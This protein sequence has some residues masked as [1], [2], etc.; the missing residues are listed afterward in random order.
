MADRQ[1]VCATSMQAG[2]GV[3]SIDDSIVE[4][5]YTD[6]NCLIEMVGTTTM[7]KQGWSS[8]NSP[9]ARFVHILRGLVTG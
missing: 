3:N 9:A 2:A 4:K 1:T 7:R 5:P 6:E 8:I